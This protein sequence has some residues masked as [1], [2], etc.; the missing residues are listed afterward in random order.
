MT[1]RVKFQIPSTK[2]QT[3]LK[4]QVPNDQ[5]SSLIAGLF[6]LV[7]VIDILGHWVLF[8]ICYV[9]IVIWQL[10]RVAESR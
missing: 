10:S 5:R 2:S 3:I 7:S 8:E 1:E 4:Y 9:A 6:P